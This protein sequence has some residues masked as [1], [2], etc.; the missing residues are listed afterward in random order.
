M[1]A[2]PGVDH[3]SSMA[4]QDK[5]STYLSI[6]KWLIPIRNK[7]ENI[8]TTIERPCTEQLLGFFFVAG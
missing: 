8:R 5:K 3:S 4:R 7:E 1:I 6:L 2:H